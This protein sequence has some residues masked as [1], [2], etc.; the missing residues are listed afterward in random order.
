MLLRA[1][2]GQMTEA[3]MCACVWMKQML[4]QRIEE[5]GCVVSNKQNDI[6]RLPVSTKIRG[7][8]K[9]LLLT[10][11][12]MLP[13]T[14]FGVTPPGTNID[15]VATATF[16]VAG[17]LNSTS[18]TVTVVSTI[19]STPSTVTFYQY[20]PSGGGTVNEE[21]PTQNATSGPPAAGYVV[22]ANPTVV[23]PGVGA[24][25]LDPSLPI[26]MN[27]VDVYLTGEPV[28]IQLVDLDQNLDPTVQETI[29]VTVITSSGDE[30]SLI[31]T[32]TDVNT[33]T[34]IGYV[35]STSN[36]VTNFDGVLSI[37]P[38]INITVDYVDQYDGSDS[39]AASTLIDPY[40]VVFNSANG[41]PLDGIVVTILD[42]LGNPATVYGED[43]VST[44]PNVVTSGGTITD[45]GGTV[46]NF[47]VGS[48][49]FPLLVPGDYQIVLTV[50]PSLRAPS[51]DTI[52]NLQTL[53]TAPYALD[54]NASFGAVFTLQAGPPLHVDIPVDPR[55]SHLSLNKKASKAHA[56]VGDFVQYT[57]T[58]D[59]IDTLAI[60][61]NTVITD[62]LPA[63][64]RYQQSS[65]RVNGV[66]AAEPIISSDARSLQFNVGT[67]LPGDSVEVK[68]VTEVS[69]ATA[70]GNAINTAVA[71]DD[72]NVSSNTA[73][74]L[75]KIFEDLIKSRSFIVGKVINADCGEDDRDR[76]GFPNAR[77]YMEDG[78]YVVTDKEGLYHFEGVTP[79]VHVVQLDVESIPDNL[80]IVA[81]EEN[82]RFAGTAHS[83]F[84][85]VKGGSMWRANFYVREKD[86]I[87]DIASLSLESDL[88]NE[89]IKYVVNMSNGNVPVTNYRLMV[90]LPR[91]VHYLPGSSHIGSQKLDD[92]EMI[93]N[94]LTYRLGDLNS[95]WIKKLEFQARLRDK[96]DGELITSSMFVVD[97]G[98]KKGVRS[99]PVKNKL[100]VKRGRLVVKDMVFQAHFKRMGTELTERSKK[101]IRLII[102]K[103]KG[104]EV[105][106]NHV[107]GHTDGDKVARRSSWLFDT[108]DDLSKGRALAVS[109]F[110]TRELQV[111]AETVKLEGR[112]RK[113]PVATNNT[114]EGRAKNRRAE[115]YI[116]TNEIVDPGSVDLTMSKSEVVTTELMGQPE[117]EIDKK[118]NPVPQVEQS[119]I[120]DFDRY[121]IKTAKPGTEWLMPTTDSSPSIPAVNLAVKYNPV[122][123]TELLQ[124]GKPVNPLFNFGTIKNKSNTVARVYWQGIH[125]QHG[126]N[127]FEFIVRAKNGVEKQRLTRNVTVSGS[128]VRA[129]LVEKYSR[130]VADGTYSPVIAV[131]LFDKDNY[132][133]RPGS[134]GKFEVNSPYIARQKIDEMD[135]SRLTGLDRKKP[136]YVVGAEGVALIELEPTTKSGNVVVK[137]PFSGKKYSEIDVWL[138]PDLREW[139]LVGLAEGTAGYNKVTG[140]LQGL[141]ESDNEDG[142]YSDGR[143]AFFAKGK[144]KGSWLIT[145]SY[146]SAKGEYDT[147]NRVN[148]LI[149]PNTYY[150]IYGD[151]S[152][153]RYD[154]SSSE[155]L[156]L[157][158]EREQ[159][160]ALYGDFNTGMNVT[161][162]SR[163][164]RSMTGFKSEIDLGAFS[165][166]IFAA[167]NLNNFI[168]DEIPGDGTS[169]L[170]RFSNQDLVINSEKIVIETRDR[171]RS[172]VIV[173]TRT[174]TRHLDY[175]IDYQLGTI[176]FRE[177]ISSRDSGF[178]PIYIIADYEVESP[179]K[180]GVTAGGRAAIKLLD[181]DLELG[182]SAVRDATFAK[183]SNLIGVDAKL[184]ISDET[185]VKFEASTTD[186]DNAG[187]AVSGN[188]MLAEIAHK[189]DDLQARV[190]VK[191]QDADF[192]LGQQ[193]GTQSGT[194]KIG[195]EGRYIV[196]PQ[197][198]VDAL[199]YR[200]EN[201]S[202]QAVRNIAEA[203]VLYAEDVYS[204]SAGARLARDTD[205]AGQSQDSDLLLLGAKTKLFENRLRLRVNTE[206]ALASSNESTDYPSRYIVGADYYLT[207]SIDLFA[208]NE[209]TMGD[210]QDTEMARMGLRASPWQG[211]KLQS[212]VSRD[213]QENGERTFASMGLTQNFRISERMTGDL[214]FDKSTTIREPG[215]VPLNIN[216]PIAQGT[217]NDDYTA[218][219][220]GLTYRAENYTVVSRLESRKAET[221]DKVG[222]VVNWERKLI[223]GVAYAIATQ[224]FNTDR[225]DGSSSVDTDIRLSLGYRP[226]SSNW[227]SL[228]RLEYKLDEEESVL[229]ITTRQRKLVNNYV[230]NYKPDHENQLSINYGVKYVIDHFD[231]DEYNGMTHLLG[232]EYRHDFTKLIDLGVHVHTLY[233]ANSNNYL[234]STGLSVG[235]QL[236]RNVWLS[237]GYN[238]DGFDDRD[239]SAA[240]YTA[241]G[242]YL[243]FRMK[244]DQDTGAEISNWFK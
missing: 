141:S 75:V 111:N 218:V 12:L 139:I 213:T 211:A 124:N 243:Q 131:R 102:N 224:A 163:F 230:T 232:S 123:K 93:E 159:F 35:Q 66:A 89:E 120:K 22:S 198:S 19:I 175:N 121:W 205:G 151:G 59:N 182:A 45:G 122:D 80:E 53:P 64:F 114:I 112:G 238:L 197:T 110:L 38:D 157:K 206:T 16:D 41:T 2:F 56:A 188:A 74:A 168:K 171:F 1:C 23:L 55:I 78:S 76:T 34:F 79:G 210:L 167:E 98:M 154:A 48:Y 153:Q 57:L 201:L 51:L 160:Y 43:G 185:K 39:S 21:V 187:V 103:F 130:L 73:T 149:D 216:V 47:P 127:K 209:W 84:V 169:G 208:E 116:T 164:N 60:S 203:N 162:L 113:Q 94:I 36:P 50:A 58:L 221:E 7:Y 97:T 83:Q 126:V 174:L 202:T 189:S 173:D 71:V 44:Y 104:A 29:V 170:Y 158:V 222:A 5:T 91:H 26:S 207:S 9:T 128:P 119:T 191:Q 161:E 140:N 92:P 72:L 155:K 236:A 204:L 219:S 217:N 42:S 86:P 8:W 129:E 24:S 137:L 65:V 193:S 235:F 237:L 14:V 199:T 184:T 105:T 143:V 109:N 145:T 95:N 147:D 194:R 67:L 183:E 100:Q 40:G 166:S 190:Y 106:L 90:V 200:E 165:Y 133:V 52:V 195:A 152:N 231:G 10:V 68:Y 17:P 62:L 226:N 242:P 138:Q 28:F 135:E 70:N 156:Y 108:N 69:S 3:G 125:L 82:T 244:F 229:G 49:Q 240:G 196:S 96:A 11:V 225:A 87:K 13:A 30:E 99:L 31:L 144:I 150:T 234:Y 134:V 223:D 228:D 118:Y 77:I 176:Y 227:I 214:A 27:P 212:S 178:N 180:G 18:N 54:A 215:A 117:Y 25:V 107:I 81:C 239:F 179:V 85:D 241:Q 15:N 148:Q 20:D 220:T 63:G 37:G 88:N 6:V 32:E 115:L 132:L 233:S 61:N 142:S 33:G 186:G 46:Y 192:G 172:E 181:D 4:A 177:P 146:D 136:E 101:A